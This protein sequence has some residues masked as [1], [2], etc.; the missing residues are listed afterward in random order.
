MKRRGGTIPSEVTITQEVHRAQEDH[1]HI[2]KRIG[3]H[4]RRGGIPDADFKKFHA[5]MVD[6]DTD[7][8]E[9]AL[10]GER[11]QS[12]GETENFR[13]MDPFLGILFPGNRTHMFKYFLC[14]PLFVEL[15]C[16]CPYS[17][18]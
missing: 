10:K 6:E 12:V 7:L 11:K 2:V 9:A 1:N 13:K 4:N 8:M 18:L 5:T 17:K 14:N 16:G 3:D 15:I